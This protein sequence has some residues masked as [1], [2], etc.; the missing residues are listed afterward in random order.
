[1]DLLATTQ[2][3]GTLTSFDVIQHASTD[4]DLPPSNACCTHRWRSTG[5]AL[6]LHAAASI[7][8]AVTS[9]LRG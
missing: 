5:E 1:M 6:A 3:Y 9:T 8:A 7:A 4:Q 2:A